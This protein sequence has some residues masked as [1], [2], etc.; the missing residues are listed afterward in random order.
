M[1][2]AQVIHV[3]N[4]LA[5]LDAILSDF[6]RGVLFEAINKRVQS[7]GADNVPN[8]KATQSKAG[9]LAHFYHFVLEKVC[10]YL[11]N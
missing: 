6:V 11:Q 5:I 10:D 4:A 3:G 8:D 9:R 2:D 7:R 1:L